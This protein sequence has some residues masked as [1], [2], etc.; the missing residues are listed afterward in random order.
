MGPLDR[1]H[2]HEI[3]GEG[4]DHARRD[5]D[6]EAEIGPVCNS[7]AAAQAATAA[8]TMIAPCERLRTPDTPKMSVNPVAPS[9][10]ERADGETIDQNCQNSMQGKP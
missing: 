6:Q 5:A 4:Q 10:I 3:S 8:A 9:I 2:R 1:F 7:P